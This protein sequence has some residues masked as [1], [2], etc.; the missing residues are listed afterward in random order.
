MLRV[1]MASFSSRSMDP[2]REVSWFVGGFLPLRIR[3]PQHT[4]YVCS[5]YAV[6]IEPKPELQIYH[7]SPGVRAE[8]PVNLVKQPQIGERLLQAFHAWPLVV[9][10]QRATR[11]FRHHMTV[12]RARCRLPDEADCYHGWHTRIG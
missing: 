10:L 6:W 7:R 5:C 9:L 12:E 4:E 11:G 2:R 1:I 3:Q 8:L